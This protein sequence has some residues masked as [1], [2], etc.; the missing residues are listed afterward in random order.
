MKR[1][2]LQIGDLVI[3]HKEK[4]S[5]RPGPRATEVQPAARG[6]QYSYRVPKFWRVVETRGDSVVLMTRTGKHHIV[7]ASNDSLRHATWWER[8]RHRRRFPDQRE[9]STEGSRWGA[10]DVNS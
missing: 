6:D 5:E 7:S 9:A 1:R 8:W 3:F 10:S 2:R 4:V